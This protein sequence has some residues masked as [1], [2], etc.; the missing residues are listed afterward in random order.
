MA[1]PKVDPVKVGVFALLLVDLALTFPLYMQ[2]LASP[3]SEIPTG[4]VAPAPIKLAP[5]LDTGASATPVAPPSPELLTWD[6]FMAV[7]GFKGAGGGG[8]ESADTE[9]AQATNLP[10]G[11][12]NIV[13]HGI[14]SLNG[15]YRA[16]ISIEGAPSVE[17]R[18][19]MTLPGTDIK[20]AD[21]HRDAV[22]LSQPGALNT[23]LRLRQS[24]FRAQPWY[25]GEGADTSSNLGGR[26]EM[27]R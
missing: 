10:I 21:I 5:S 26:I 23:P 1:M 9:I 6:P 2:M 17:V 25:Q 12:D 14:I 16:L 27:R 13:L 4:F 15:Q 8:T 18:K 19:G 11:T 3:E 20:A 22:L 7:K 24:E